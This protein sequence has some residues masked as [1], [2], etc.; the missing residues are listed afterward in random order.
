MVIP[1]TVRYT[2]LFKFIPIICNIFVNNIGYNL[3]Q[4]I[5]V[6]ILDGRT[7]QYNFWGKNNKENYDHNKH[8]K[9]NL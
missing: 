1:V 5:Y 6:H 8:K 4:Y 7:K 9:Y 3:G 2:A